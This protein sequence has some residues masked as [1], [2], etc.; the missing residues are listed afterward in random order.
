MQ[1]LKQST[2]SQEIPLGYFLD[3]TDGTTA[4]TGLTIANTDIQLFKGGATSMADKNSGGATHMAGGLYST[5]LDATDTDTLG[6][7]T[8]FTNVAG[9]LPT[10]STF[11]VLPSASYDALV[12]NGLN[13]ISTTEVNTECD[14]AISDA[15]LATAASL[16]TVD[17]NVDAIL[18]DTNELQS[19]DTPGALATLSGKV[20]VIDGIVDAILTYTGTTLPA[21]LT[22][23]EGKIDTVDTNVDSV[24]VDTGTTLDGKLDTIDTVVDSILVDT[25]TTLDGKLTSIESKIDTVD[26]N[27]DS[28]L[29][30]TGTT[31][32]AN[33]T[34]IKAKTDNITFTNSGEV[35]SNVKSVNDTEVTGDGGSGTEWGP[36]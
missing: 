35:D 19:D 32:D 33:I 30:D 9:A 25:G 2:A 36:V 7:L 6:I 16:A 20:D 28:I 22:T 3:D 24:L 21:T 31:L 18:V 17:T 11:M 13:D 26:T 12:T 4:E 14:T 1:Y 27:V 15:S 34:A 29:V 23:I 10:K 8:I 5:V